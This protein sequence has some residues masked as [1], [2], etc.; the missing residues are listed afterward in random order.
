[1]MGFKLG[2]LGKNISVY[3]LFATCLCVWFLFL[4]SL[5]VIAE[6]RM[7]H[8]IP[9]AT[10]LAGAYT[11]YLSCLINTLMTP[12]TKYGKWHS[13]VG[14]V[15]MV[16]GFASFGLGFYCTWLSGADV[17]PGFQVGIT[18]GGIAQV[19]SQVIGW[20]AIKRYKLRSKQIDA[21]RK[22]E[23]AD[24]DEDLDEARAK[25]VSE[26]ETALADHVKSMISLYAV[27]CG[28][29]AMIRL[30][31]IALPSAGVV[32]LVGAVVG[33]S[34]LVE[35]FANTYLQTAGHA[36]HADS[37]GPRKASSTRADTY[38]TYE[39]PNQHQTTS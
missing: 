25:L 15:G 28:S 26:K 9:L 24:R 17:D 13:T 3:W 34:M 33:L 20:R 14:K 11:V 8:D 4:H 6:R 29:P 18:I 31:G 36:A 12:S 1:M 2:G 32:G 10:H 37:A 39:P 22:G 30:V 7:Y 35:P 16:S 19:A 21:L 23:T 27:A 5:P 38:G